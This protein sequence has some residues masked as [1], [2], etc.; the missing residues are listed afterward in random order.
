[1]ELADRLGIGPGH[2][3]ERST[4]QHQLHL[5]PL[6]HL[7]R[8]DAP[9]CHLRLQQIYTVNRNPSGW[10]HSA[11]RAILINPTYRGTRV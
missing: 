11:M 7:A 8:T 10:S 2:L 5:P 6:L 1:M 9:P 3:G 4:P